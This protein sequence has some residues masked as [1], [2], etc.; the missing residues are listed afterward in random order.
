MNINRYEKLVSQ[1]CILFSK[2]VL[3][4]LDAS[5]CVRCGTPFIARK[6]QQKYIIREGWN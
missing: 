4:V 5:M 6:V 3:L 1:A 2:I